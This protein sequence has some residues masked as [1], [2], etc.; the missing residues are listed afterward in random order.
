M[1]WSDMLAGLSANNAAQLY[2]AVLQGGDTSRLFHQCMRHSSSWAAADRRIVHSA[3]L[4]PYLARKMRESAKSTALNTSVCLR[5]SSSCRINSE[6]SLGCGSATKTL[7]ASVGSSFNIP[8]PSGCPSSSQLNLVRDEYQP[9][10]NVFGS[11][12][13]ANRTDRKSTRLNSSH[14]YIS[15]A[16]FC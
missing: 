10:T 6:T 13:F 9:A 11:Q 5:L 16:V 3:A 2:K 12:G 15:Y 7:S 8:P 1:D 4:S 14:G